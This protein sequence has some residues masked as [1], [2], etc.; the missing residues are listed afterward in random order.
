ME[1]P[2]PSLEKYRVVLQSKRD[3]LSREIL[4]ATSEIIN[5][6]EVFADSVDQAAADTGRT[7]NVQMQNRER[8]S[9]FK[10]DAA[11]RKIEAGS[12]GQ[13]ESCNDEI[14]EAR[15]MANLETTLCISCQMEYET[16]RQRFSNRR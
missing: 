15:I 10:L 12:F 1:S 2:K 5:D 11:L 6:E 14:S 3:A 16:E 8:E 13:C 9:L 4:A 7:L